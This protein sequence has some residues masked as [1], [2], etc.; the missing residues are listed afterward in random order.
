MSIIGYMPSSGGLSAVA[1]AASH[2]QEPAGDPGRVYFY[3]AWD[4]YGSLSNFS[5]HPIRIVGGRG[6]IEEWPTVEAR[7]RAQVARRDD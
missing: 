3:K 1:D 4:A 7:L 2:L 6:E 5:P